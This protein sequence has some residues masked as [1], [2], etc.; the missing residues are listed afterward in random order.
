MKPQLHILVPFW[1]LAGGVI[2][3]LDYAQ[4][5]QRG[6]YDVTLW[7]PA[8]GTSEPL[9][10]SLPVME[11]IRAGGVQFR[12]LEDLAKVQLSEHD[13]L[14]F[15]EPAHA[16]IVDRIGAPAERLIHLVQGT[17]HAT[18]TWNNGLHYRLLHRPFVRIAVSEQVRSA[19]APH[20]HPALPLHL[21]PEGHD[22][23]YFTVERQAM[24]TTS[25]LRVLYN[26]WK[27]DLGDAVAKLCDPTEV[28]F[29]AIRSPMSWPTLRDHYR[30]ADIFLAA[31]GPEEGF[32]LPGLE[33]MAAQCAVVMAL[34]GGNEAYGVPG[35]NMVT[36][37]FDDPEEHAAALSQLAGDGDLR[38][39]VI[40]AGLIT[41]RERRLDQERTAALKI[42]R[43]PLENY[44]EIASQEVAI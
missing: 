32:Y 7:A 42:L 44:D 33:A 11:R 6:G 27:S 40:A 41:A 17:R 38:S 30:D 15:T 22:I 18:P 24:N 23:D 31:P 35:H 37:T 21:V 8:A 39:R 1:G 36:A 26:T 3:V 13:R 16:A 12:V 43:S 10:T 29:T 14:L 9:M 20:V 28:V 19:I 34:V 2:K 25:P 4:H 5:G